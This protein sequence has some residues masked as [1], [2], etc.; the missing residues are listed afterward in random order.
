[1]CFGYRFSRLLK[2]DPYHNAGLTLQIGCLVE[3]SDYNSECQ[4]EQIL[5]GHKDIYF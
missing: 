3:F 2:A 4:F 5:E 1:M